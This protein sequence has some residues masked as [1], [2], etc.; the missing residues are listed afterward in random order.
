MEADMV[1][2]VVVGG[3]GMGWEGRRGRRKWSRETAEFNG[4]QRGHGGAESSTRSD[5][6]SAHWQFLMRPKW[7]RSTVI[8]NH[9]HHHHHHHHRNTGPAKEYNSCC[10]LVRSKKKTTTPAAAA[11][12]GFRSFSLYVTIFHPSRPSF[13]KTKKHQAIMCSSAG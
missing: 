11:F 12:L 5:Q 7:E 6:L 2:V 9:H 10:S 1:V 4:Q 3:D 13:P 8:I